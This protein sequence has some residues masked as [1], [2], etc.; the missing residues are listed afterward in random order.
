MTMPRAYWAEMTTEE[1]AGLEGAGLVAILPLAAIEQHG[2]HLPLSTDA[3]ICAGILAAAMARRSPGLPATA[4]PPILVTKSDEH[5]GF[6]GTLSLTAETL[7]D[8]I[9]QTAAGLA[10][11]GL[12]KLVLLNGHGGNR[13]IMGLA[14]GRLRAEH[15]M[16]VAKANTSDL[17][18]AGTAVGG[19]EARLG[20][21]GGA[22][23]TALMLHLKP[24]LVR[25][26]RIARF[27]SLTA[28]MREEGYEKL[29]PQG[30]HGFYW[31]AGDLNP[32]GVVGDATKA[33][34]ALGKALTGQAADSLIA[35]LEEVHRFDVSRLV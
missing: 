17:Y 26:D 9:C 33:T 4:L 35:L 29:S 22:V 14:A 3:D 18:D 10:R 12:R 11:L 15:G 24:D 8:A 16:L 5:A 28:A 7:V 6:P 30:P 34:A 32:A 21:H 19:E 23:E 13:D 1:V 31:H 20:I 27:E 2:P 25:K